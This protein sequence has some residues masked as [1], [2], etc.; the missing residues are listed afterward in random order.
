M[1]DASCKGLE[2][3]VE[4]R[5]GKLHYKLTCQQNTQDYDILSYRAL[6][7]YTSVVLC[8]QMN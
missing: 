2:L 8:V 3:Q 1:K 7:V 5:L 4:S 6:G